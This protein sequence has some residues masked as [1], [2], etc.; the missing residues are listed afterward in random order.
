M[1]NAHWLAVV[2]GTFLAASCAATPSEPRSDQD[3]EITG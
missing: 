1:R 2:A 3:F